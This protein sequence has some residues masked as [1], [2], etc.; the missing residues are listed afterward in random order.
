MSETL[1]HY[2]ERAA[3]ADCPSCGRL[4]CEEHGGEVCLRCMAPETAVPSARVFRGSLAA[5]GLVTLITA[6]LLI[7]PPS[8]GG[9]APLVRELPSPTPAVTATATP[10][11][12]GGQ[13]SPTP[14]PGT[15]AATTAPG[16]ATASPAA[17]PTAQAT[18]TPSARVYTVKS[19]DTLFQIALDNGTTV[20][21]IL[22]VNPGL[23]PDTLTVGM[24]IR[25]P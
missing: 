8:S 5:L 4:Y 1:C 7:R 16:T 14:Q 22:A 19:G 17:S 15:P 13:P 20:D 10:T 25:L 24:E 11:P 23:D 9:E 18:P 21:A 3:V 2:C 12:R 6:F